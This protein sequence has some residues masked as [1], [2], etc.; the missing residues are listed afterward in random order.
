[1]KYLKVIKESFLKNIKAITFCAVII[2]IFLNTLL[3]VQ[4]R[5][6]SKMATITSFSTAELQGTIRGILNTNFANIDDELV[7]DTAAIGDLASL[8]TAVKTNLVASSNEVDEHA[9]TANTSVG[10]LANLTTTAKT[11]LVVATNEINVIQ[12]PV[13]ISSFLNSWVNYNLASHRGA[14]YYK[15]RGRVYLQGAIKD[16]SLTHAAF[17]LPVGYRPSKIIY[18]PIVAGTS[19]SYVVIWTDGDVSIYGSDNS[20]VSLEELSFEI[21]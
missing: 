9:D 17:N 20:L 4:E 16:G 6:D 11:D 2:L 18:L 15:Y 19:F 13:S 7:I 10:T 8:T 3:M 5:N 1:M 14:G 12:S 21:S